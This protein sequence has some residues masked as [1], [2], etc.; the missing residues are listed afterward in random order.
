MYYRK[1]LVIFLKDSS[2]SFLDPD[3]GS[4][5]VLGHS[6][7]GAPCKNHCAKVKTHRAGGEEPNQDILLWQNLTNQ[8]QSECDG[9][10]DDFYLCVTEWNDGEED[11]YYVLIIYGISASVKTTVIFRVRI[12]ERGACHPYLKKGF[13]QMITGQQPRIGLPL[14]TISTCG[15]GAVV[16]E[17]R[18]GIF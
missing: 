10:E 6:G 12:R 18:Q 9:Q 14:E 7:N 17:W 4:I 8:S 16:A 5:I 2:I 15:F 13:T 3:E 1:H 11:E